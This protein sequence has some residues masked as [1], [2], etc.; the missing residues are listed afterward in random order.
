[1][2][3][4]FIF[5]S[6]FFIFLIFSKKINTK[7]AKI[8]QYYDFQ[9]I[10][11]LNESFSMYKYLKIH[12]IEKY[13][14]E[15]FKFSNK[16]VNEAGKIEI[17]LN[18]LPKNFYEV[19]A[20]FILAISVIYFTKKNEN[21]SEIL[22]FL[23]FLILA[24]GRIIPSL[25]RITNSLQG[26]RFSKPSVQLLAEE[27]NKFSDLEN[28][29]SKISKIKL[30]KIELKNI[31]FSYGKNKIFEN[32]NLSFYKG[33]SLGIVGPTGSGKST[34][35]DILTGLLKADHGEIYLNNKMIANPLYKSI[36]I[37]YV[38]QN[39][40]LFDG[41]IRDN[42]FFDERDINKINNN[43]VN[44]IFK[45]LF[46]DEF[47]NLRDG[48]DTYIG[49]NATNISGGQKQ[50]LGLAR[51]L[52]QEPELLILDES[53]NAINEDMQI[54]I[55]ENLKKLKVTLCL[56]AHNNKLIEKCEKKILINN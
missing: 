3:I 13:F 35:L 24:I 52:I 20:I 37:A 1:M 36:K 7:Y 38:P 54:K 33:E 9:Q 25:T 30:D 40:V 45:A 18:E 43:S 56:I 22:P 11:N 41:T 15:K 47:L 34:L 17:F 48:L 23:G 2:L 27:Y 46:L 44:S 16:K 12:Q 51:A 28:E 21:F 14:T 29:D 55:L 6:I 26:I 49:E 5:I 42:L 4:F 50:R 32:F 31:S 10:K 8:R 39:I 19:I 53:T